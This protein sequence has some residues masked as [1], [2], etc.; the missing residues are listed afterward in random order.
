MAVKPIPDGYHSVTPY[1]TIRGAAK[2]IDFYKAAFGAV[3]V[4]RMPMPDGSV[5]H[6]EIKIGD[7]VI[8]MG[9]EKPEWG[10]KSPETLGGTASGLMIY[11]PDCDAVF[12]AALAHGATVMKPLADQFYGDRSGSVIDP[13][14]HTWTVATHV[15]DVE[16]AEMQKRMDAM[17]AQ[18]SQGGAA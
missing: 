16:P 2:A 5:A 13:F 4:L 15:E 3:E 18:M 1:M 12:A 6:A 7:S 10:N 11:V 9:E 14:G 8:M 17:M